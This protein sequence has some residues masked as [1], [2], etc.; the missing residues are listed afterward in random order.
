MLSSTANSKRVPQNGSKMASRQ[1]FVSPF[2]FFSVLSFTF[3]LLSVLSFTLSLP[4]SFRGDTKAE[5]KFKHVS[6][7]Y[8]VLSDP[9]TKEVYDRTGVE[10]I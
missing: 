10:V 8:R 9:Q 6:D 3:A 7:A 1:E 4:P 5:E 2:L